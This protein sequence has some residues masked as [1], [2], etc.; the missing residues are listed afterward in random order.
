MKSTKRAI[1]DLTVQSYKQKAKL[2]NISNLLS[3]LNLTSTKSSLS[4][5]ICQ[6]PRSGKATTSSGKWGWYW[7]PTSVV[8]TELLGEI[9]VLPDIT[10][11]KMVSAHS[12]YPIYI[13][14][15]NYYFVVKK[16]KKKD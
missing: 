8:S 15:Y 13:S 6:G 9:N 10:T 2:K 14:Y 3:T 12:E 16:K 7:K 11:L 1:T 5:R 4:R